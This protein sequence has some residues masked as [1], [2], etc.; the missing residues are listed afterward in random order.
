MITEVYN[1]NKK[2]KGVT[3]IELLVSLFVLA[4]GLLALA[5]A[6][7]LILSYDNE[8]YFTS[9]AVVRL[10]SLAE[11]LFADPKNLSIEIKRWNDINA[12]LLPAGSGSVSGKNPYELMIHWQEK[13][14]HKELS[15]QIAGFHHETP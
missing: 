13:S 7:L 15:L 2:A 11:R 1:K 14:K 3:L 4:V 10:Q 8:A 12:I 6:Q 9:L 5:K